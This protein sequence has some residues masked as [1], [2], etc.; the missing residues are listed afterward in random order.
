MNSSRTSRS[1]CRYSSA[2]GHRV[3]RLHRELAER[4]FGESIAAVAPADEVIDVRRYPAI[5]LDTVNTS[6]SI[7]HSGRTL[8]RVEGP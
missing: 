4:L 3:Y 7:R 1:Q 8:G 5:T 6:R 2:I